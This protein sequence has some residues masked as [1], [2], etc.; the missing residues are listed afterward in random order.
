MWSF[1]LNTDLNFTIFCA[2]REGRICSIW[3]WGC[4]PESLGWGAEPGFAEILLVIS[5]FLNSKDP[6]S[7]S[8]VP[9]RSYT[10]WGGISWSGAW[11]QRG[12]FCLSK[13]WWLSG[14]ESTCQCR[15]LSFAPWSGRSSGEGNGNP[16]QYSYLGNPMNR[17]AWWAIQSMGL[18]MSQTQLWLNKKLWWRRVAPMLGDSLENVGIWMSSTVFPNI[19]GMGEPWAASSCTISR[20]SQWSA[21]H[22]AGLSSSL[23]LVIC[24]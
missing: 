18:Q 1:S 8:P 15:S 22:H 14:K 11:R 7:T 16:L 3:G 20:D 4:G 13:P 9:C 21:A 19:Q 5:T 10:N 23:S 2:R 6:N 17:G 12:W 24:K